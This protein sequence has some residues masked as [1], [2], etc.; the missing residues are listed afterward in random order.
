[1]PNGVQAMSADM[2]GLVQ[3]VREE[4]AHLPGIKRVLICGG[5]SQNSSE[6]VSAFNK[7]GYETDII[8]R[9]VGNEGLKRIAGG[10]YSRRGTMLSEVE[11]V[12]FPFLLKKAGI[13]FFIIDNEHGT[14]E[15]KTVNALAMNSGFAEIQAIVRLPNNERSMITKL[16]D[17]GVSSFLLPMTNLKEDIEKVVEYAKY[18]P[19]GKR[20]V[21]TTRAHTGYG[22]SD[23]KEY[24][25]QANKRMKIYAQI[26]TRSGVEHIEEIISVPEVEGI[27]I[28]PNDLSCDYDC[29]GDTERE[30][31][32]V[33]VICRACI[34]HGK[35]CGI[36]TND[37]ELIKH[38]LLCGCS[39]ISCGS[40]INM[41]IKETKEIA[42]ETYL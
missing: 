5:A 16:A 9:N 18:F 35:P 15:N 24:M 6:I 23:I 27:F 13:D 8:E 3:R 21:S 11:F 14:F 26:E 33:S 32:L 29:M 19:A 28:G 34:K 41:L 17:G 36:I 20:G 30:K 2:E 40:E 12:N 7:L 10:V 4:M 42:N 39:M 37:K 1:M 38:A 31:G 22:V 25:K